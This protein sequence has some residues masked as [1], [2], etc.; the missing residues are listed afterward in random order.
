MTVK[1]N[2]GK[3]YFPVHCKFVSLRIGTL[4]NVSICSQLLMPAGPREQNPIKEFTNTTTYMYSQALLT[5]LYQIWIFCSIQYYKKNFN[6]FH[7]RVFANHSLNPKTMVHLTYP[8]E[9]SVNSYWI[10][11]WWSLRKYSLK[12]SLITNTFD[13]KVMLHNYFTLVTAVL[14]LNFSSIPKNHSEI[15]RFSN[16]FEIGRNSNTGH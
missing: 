11:Q 5:V 12:H 6:T 2:G 13:S 15:H 7:N 3:I 14:R 10:L 16:C 8:A 1:K 4:K 9:I